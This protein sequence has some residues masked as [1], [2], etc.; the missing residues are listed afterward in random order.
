MRR[1]SEISKTVRVRDLSGGMVRKLDASKLD[2]RYARDAKNLRFQTGVAKTREGTLRAA[3]LTRPSGAVTFAGDLAEYAK[4]YKNPSCPIWSGLP[5][6]FT[7]EWIERPVSGAPGPTN[8]GRVLGVDDG[9]SFDSFC[10]RQPASGTRQRWFRVHEDGEASPYNVD[11][12]DLDGTGDTPDDRRYYCRVR[13]KGRRLDTLIRGGSAGDQSA[14]DTTLFASAS[15]T[16]KAT[17]G[18]DHLFIGGYF[19][20]GTV[21]GVN[22]KI[23]AVRIW[24]RYLEDTT[25]S[26]WTGHPVL[27]D[28]KLYLWIDFDEDS[29]AA[30]YDH[31]VWGN[32]GILVGSPSRV[33]G[34]VTGLM[35]GQ[36]IDEFTPP[37]K[38]H[39]IIAAGGSVFREEVE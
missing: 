26:M 12:G 29:G 2:T 37:G 4:I 24:G 7:I 23:D 15:S 1:R 18:L 36:A 35:V 39:R 19:Y 32:H 13:R 30:I 25:K 20:G 14:V 16:L 17:G 10:V 8:E 22:S 11:M 33:A 5:H 34:V 38:N 27:E 28:P 3:Q 6:E 21:R 9:S 31:S